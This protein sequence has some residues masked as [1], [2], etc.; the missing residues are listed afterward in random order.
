MIL[1]VL[2]LKR[3]RRHARAAV[4]DRDAENADL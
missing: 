1:L 3:D 4:T 2:R